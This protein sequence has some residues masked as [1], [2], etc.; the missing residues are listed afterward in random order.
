[1]TKTRDRVKLGVP[2]HRPISRL[3]FP[4]P[5]IDSYKGIIDVDFGYESAKEGFG[6][7]YFDVVYSNFEKEYPPERSYDLGFTIPENCTV[8][9]SLSKKSEWRWPP[10]TDGMTS[11]GRFP[12]SLIRDYT[13]VKKATD[14]ISF[15]V[16]KDGGKPKKYYFYLN[17]EMA[18]SKGDE[19]WRPISID[20]WLENP[21]PSS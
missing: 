18:Q 11:K 16:K 4:L 3:P 12:R 13:E 14:V 19:K 7:F 5:K 17:V 20:P 8:N 1:M 21:R 9:I 15:K 6:Q 2:K 10:S